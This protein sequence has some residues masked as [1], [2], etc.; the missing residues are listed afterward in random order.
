MRAVDHYTFLGTIIIPPDAIWNKYT[1]DI[2]TESL[3]RI[4]WRFKPFYYQKFFVSQHCEN[5]IPFLIFFLLV[6]LNVFFP[7]L[8]PQNHTLE[9]ASRWSAASACLKGLYRILDPSTVK[10]EQGISSLTSSTRLWASS[11]LFSVDNLTLF[12]CCPTPKE[13]CELRW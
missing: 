2:F 1:K 10:G 6:V 13:I 5:P 8:G 9:F 3:S 11:L 4:H 12:L 7:P